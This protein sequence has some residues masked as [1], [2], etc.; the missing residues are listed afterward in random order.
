MIYLLSAWLLFNIWFP[1][2]LHAIGCE[3]EGM[4]GFDDKNKI[5]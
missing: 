5:Q 3:R 2:V 4:E 1:F